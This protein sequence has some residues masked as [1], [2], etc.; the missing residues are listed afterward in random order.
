MSHSSNKFKTGKMC[1]CR[2]CRRHSAYKQ[3][4]IR[5]GNRVFR[6]LGR[7]QGISTLG[8]AELSDFVNQKVGIDYTD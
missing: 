1:G 7:I 5:R 2:H 3:F 8:D 6:K 4:E